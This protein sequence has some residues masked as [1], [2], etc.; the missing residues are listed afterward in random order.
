MI[1]GQQKTAKT[2]NKNKWLPHIDT[3]TDD[4]IG[5]NSSSPKGHRVCRK[6]V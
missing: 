6:S 5:K 3:Y 4:K 2:Q 1:F